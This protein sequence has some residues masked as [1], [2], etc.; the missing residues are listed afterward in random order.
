MDVRRINESVLKEKILIK[1]KDS[2]YLKMKRLAFLL[3]KDLMPEALNMALK[4][5]GGAEYEELVK[6]TP[7]WFKIISWVIFVYVTMGI[8]IIPFL[9]LNK[10][11]CLQTN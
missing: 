10:R 2:D 5:S 8:C 1:N 4:I 9:V 7:L 3:Q 6:Y 11:I